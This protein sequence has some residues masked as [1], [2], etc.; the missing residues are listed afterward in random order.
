[1]S[2]NQPYLFV[3]GTLREDMGHEMYHLLA[4]DASFVGEA[5]VAGT[6]YDLGRYPGLIPNG[7][8]E[9]TVKG[10]VYRIHDGVLDHTL[11]TLDEYEGIGPEDPMP[12]EYRRE[13]V[14]TSLDDGRRLEAWAYILN[15]PPK[16][17]REIHSGD[18]RQF[19]KTVGGV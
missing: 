14:S 9:G 2:R 10:E 11:E 7:D 15:R 8:A 18:Y 13:I 5:T 19:R 16:G 4:R 3:Y 17:L 12:H 6:L 1:M